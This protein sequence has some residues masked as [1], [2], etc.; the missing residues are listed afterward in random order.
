MTLIYNLI[1]VITAATETSTAWA[2]SFKAA[3]N[4]ATGLQNRFIATRLGRALNIFV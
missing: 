3:H 4:I 1:G 2:P